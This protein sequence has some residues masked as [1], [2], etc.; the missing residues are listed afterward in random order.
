M[1]PRLWQADQITG[2]PMKF[3]IR[4]TRHVSSP[5]CPFDKKLPAILEN[6]NPLQFPEAG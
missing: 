5:Q 6:E 1:A 3:R 4:L 2:E